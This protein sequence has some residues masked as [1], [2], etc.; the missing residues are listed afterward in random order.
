LPEEDGPE[1]ELTL[2]G[3]SARRPPPRES[4]DL[5]SL[6]TMATNAP[7]F[8]IP[9]PKALLRKFNSCNTNEMRHQ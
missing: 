6:K 7:Q 9:S 5:I 1:S 3:Q 8:A 2:E 4:V